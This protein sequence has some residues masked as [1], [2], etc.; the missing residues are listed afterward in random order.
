MSKQAS[1]WFQVDKEGLAQTLE[2]KGKE[3]VVLELVQNVW[4]E[5]GATRCEITLETIAGRRGFARLV[6][7]DD[8]PDGFT[9]LADAW[10]LFAPSKKKGVAELRGRFN[11]GEKLVL[12]LCES[13]TIVSTR[14][15]VRFD[16]EGRHSIREKTESGSV[17]DAVIRFKVDDIAATK[18]AIATLIP[19]DN[20]TTIYNGE[21]VV[22]RA[23]KHVFTGTLG[24]EIADDE[25][26]L[27]PTRRKC[28]ITV[29]EPLAGETPT[30]YEMGIPV[31]ET[32]DRWHVDVGQ[33][34]P[35]NTDRDNVKPA[36]LR[37][38]RTIV[39]NEMY[40]ALTPAD[41]P[42]TFVREA[43][44]DP[45]IEPAAVTRIMDL[46]WGEKRVRF[47]PSD[48]EANKR[49]M[50]A[51]YTVIPGGAYNRDQWSNIK[52]H[53][54][55]ATKP[56]GQVTPGH[57]IDTYGPDGT[58]PTPKDKWTPTMDRLAQYSQDLCEELLG[59][60]CAVEYITDVTVPMDASW[61]GRTLTFNIGRLGRRWVDEPN[62]QKVDELLIHEFSHHSVHDHLSDA[63]HGECCR[64]GAK[65][66]HVQ[67]AL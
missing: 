33:K 44:S 54:A 9:N 29:Y 27:K 56:A 18:A 14:G 48:P 63:Y 65:M 12:A 52:T 51:G 23:S 64:L 42:S 39:T 19:P 67:S 50:A 34:V 11:V 66:R 36:W 21:V 61:G 30:L 26:Y 58:P 17:F 2:R 32:G 40:T 53:D 20:V 7:T 45:R 24:T 25:G 43:L 59:F 60:R 6:V 3:F 15:G 10:T 4:D 35:L 37:E 46:Q 57:S 5:P 62:Q 31:V 47:D 8:A 55:E 13:A 22:Q 49:A 38:L 41:A 16:G 1:D 28:T